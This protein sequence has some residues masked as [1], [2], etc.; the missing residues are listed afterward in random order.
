MARPVCKGF[1]RD[2]RGIS[3]LQRIRPR[4]SPPG[5]GVGD[6][7]AP[8][9]HKNSS[10]SCAAFNTR[11]PERAVARL[12]G[13][14]VVTLS[15]TP[16]AR[17]A[18]SLRPSEPLRGH[19]CRFGVKR[20]PALQHHPGDPRQLVGQGDD[21]D[22]PISPAHQ[23]FRPSAERRGTLGDMG[24]RGARPVNQLF[25]QILVAALA[26]PEQLRLAPGSELPRNQAQPCGEIATVVETF[27]STD[28]GNERRCD[29]RAEARGSSSADW[30][31][32]S[33]SP[34]E[35]TQ[36][37]RLQ[38]VDRAPP[39]A[40]G[41]PRRAGPCVELN[42]APPRSSISTA[43]NCSSFRLMGG[44]QAAKPVSPPNP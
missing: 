31:L 44:S 22:I 10:A 25:A 8:G 13:H 40:R 41:R 37:Q 30:P 4:R 34:S 16:L 5:R 19:G 15:Q 18:L 27:R 21:R 35:R 36:H 20:F 1:C 17:P 29:N 32:R 9:P 38:F 11:L 7:R 28:S 23:L 24:Q 42:P 2:R 3:L 33:P 6:T 26:D 43:R 12:S 14:L 39:I